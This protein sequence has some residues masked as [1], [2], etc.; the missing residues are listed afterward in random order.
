MNQGKYTMEETAAVGEEGVE[1][2]KKYLKSLSKTVNV[3]DVQGNKEF[4]IVDVD[5]LWY[6]R[7]SHKE[8]RCRETWIEVKA[9]R[10][11]KTGNYFFETVSN[12]DKNTPGCFMYTKAKYLFY[13]FIDQKELHVL[14]VE[15]VRE[16]FK[17][18]IEL[19]T[20]KSTSTKVG[21]GFDPSKGRLVKRDLVLETFPDN[22]KKIKI[23]KYLTS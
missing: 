19:F 18:N 22:A 20:E 8:G 1:D 12:K 11:Y 3:Y 10:Q 6:E 9:D 16:W 15:P 17:E 4:Q 5:L 14:E 2:C 7:Y 21:D 23:E 13:Y